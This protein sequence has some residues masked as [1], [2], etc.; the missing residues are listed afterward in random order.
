MA[1]KKMAVIGSVEQK[2]D[3][4]DR[5]GNLVTEKLFIIKNLNFNNQINYENLEILSEK[6]TFLCGSSGCGKS[7]LLRLLN[8]T[9][10]PAKGNILFHG[11]DLDSMNPLERRKRISLVAQEVFLFQGSILE[12][13]RKF[14]YYRGQS[15]PSEERMLELLSLCQLN[16]PLDSQVEVMSGGERQRLYVAI[17]LSFQPEVLLLDE[18][19]SA[20]DEANSFQLMENLISFSKTHEM[21]MVIVSHNRDLAEKFGDVIIQ[22]G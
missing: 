13:F 2:D 5:K 3:L 20:L 22:M 8:G 9:I 7:T 21:A 18:P 16:F 6:V 17:F 11:T 1:E 14:Y 19:T 15:L 10:S 4:K 12:N